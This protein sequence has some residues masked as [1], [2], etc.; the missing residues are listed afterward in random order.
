MPLY[1]Y[2][3]KRVHNRLIIRVGQDCWETLGFNKHFRI[4]SLKPKEVLSH[5]Q[6]TRVLITCIT[7]RLRKIQKYK[8]PDLSA[9]LLTRHDCCP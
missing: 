9:V 3:L 2:Y 5:F 8:I 6:K 1:K 4:D 7:Y